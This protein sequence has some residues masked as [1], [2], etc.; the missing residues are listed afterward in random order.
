MDPNA[1]DELITLVELQQVYDRIG[2]LLE[3][4]NSPPTAVRELE[5][6]NLE[7]RGRLDEQKQQH[8]A[9]EDELR[10]VV[11][12]LE[13]HR[14]ELEHFQKQRQQVT[15]E[16]EFRAVL[17]EID[18]AEKALAESNVRREALEGQIGE[19]AGVVEEL[20]R[21]QP[22]EEK[23]QSDV[24][25]TWQVR[26]D[27]IQEKVHGLAESVKEKEK[28]LSPSTRARFLRL[29]GHKQGRALAEVQ[30]GSC[31]LCH[32][33]LRPHLQQR[34]RMAEEIITCEHCH[35]ILY[36]TETIAAEG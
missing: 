36:M 11:R 18:F 26:Q 28:A 6:A 32:Y 14:L 29:L 9:L 24:L 21:L 17:N 19:L 20:E 16:R 3:E 31:S 1:Q 25:K 35:R 30:E 12:R 10:E 33:E 34:L 8:K 2:S 4:R 7:R 15:N 5:E 23:R 13:E 27:E 22:E